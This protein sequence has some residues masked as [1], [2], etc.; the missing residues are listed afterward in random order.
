MPGPEVNFQVGQ[1]AVPV[2]GLDQKRKA[3]TK[4]VEILDP[5]VTHPPNGPEQKKK[6]PGEM[7]GNGQVG[8]N[9]IDHYG[10]EYIFP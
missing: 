5:A 1:R 10:N 4:E 2:Q 6:D 3:K 7:E 8:Q 9:F